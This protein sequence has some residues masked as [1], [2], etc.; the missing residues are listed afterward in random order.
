MRAGQCGEAGLGPGPDPQDG[1]EELQ[2]FL[3]FWMVKVAAVDRAPTPCPGA[4]LLPDFLRQVVGT[5]RRTRWQGHCPP[6]L[7]YS[8]GDGCPISYKNIY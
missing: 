5:Q 7:Q 4:Q 6:E 8:G 3:F 1:G 2:P